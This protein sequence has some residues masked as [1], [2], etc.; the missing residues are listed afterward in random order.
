MKEWILLLTLATLVCAGMVACNAS[1]TS[2]QRHADSTI[3]VMNTSVG[4]A[5]PEP[6][7]TGVEVGEATMTP[8]RDLIDNISRSKDHTTFIILLKASGLDQSLRKAGHYTLFV[9]SNE[10][11]N[12][13]PSGRVDSLLLPAHKTELVRL[14]HN[15]FIAGSFMLDQLRSHGQLHTLSG[16]PVT[17]FRKGGDWWINGARIS[18]ADIRTRN[19]ILFTTDNVLDP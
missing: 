16:L 14:I 9:P 7:E 13:M 8:G 4:N 10:A 17:L 5:I 6:V 19:G 18:T 12:E 2:G 15:H 3:I 1:A 11:F